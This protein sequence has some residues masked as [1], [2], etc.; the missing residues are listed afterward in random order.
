MKQSVSSDLVL[1]ADESCLIF[2]HKH[3][4]EIEN[5]SGEPMAYKTI[6]KKQTLG[7]TIYSETSTF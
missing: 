4:T 3:V 5:L 6:K 2:Q 7:S 1:Y